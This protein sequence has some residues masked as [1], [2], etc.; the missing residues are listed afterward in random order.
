MVDEGES[1]SKP[2][3][4]IELV[5]AI[6]AIYSILAEIEG[7]SG[8]SL[9]VVGMDSGSE[10]SFDFLGIAKVMHE[11]RETLQWAY[12]IVVFHRQNATIKNLQVASDTLSII[13]K[14]AKLEASKAISGED[15]ARMKHGL[16]AGL[17][18]FAATGSYIREMAHEDN[19]PALV[20]RPQPQ[21]LTGPADEIVRDANDAG[22]LKDQTGINAPD[23]AF[24]QPV[25][26]NPSTSSYSDEQIAAAIA[27]LE[28]ADKSSKSS[29]PVKPQRVRK[30]R[31]KPAA[32]AS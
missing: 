24:E 20:M 19:S 17:E 6:N 25:S 10:K 28:Q 16:F 1:L 31:K 29:E 7:L 8:S 4:I 3:R 32:S 23:K 14:V 5:S 26:S 13:G 27:I 12:N 21:L 22:A 30:P 9:A 15:A 2:S 11:L 18:K